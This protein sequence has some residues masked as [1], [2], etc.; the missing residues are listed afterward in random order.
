M[1][2][3]TDS[4]CCS[5]PP[6][7][8]F[9]TWVNFER[10]VFLFH[11]GNYRYRDRFRSLYRYINRR[12]P[13]PAME[14]HWIANIKHLAVYIIDQG[15]NLSSLDYNTFSQFKSLKTVYL[16]VQVTPSFRNLKLERNDRLADKGFMDLELAMARKAQQNPNYHTSGDWRDVILD[17][18]EA[19]RVR[20]R[21]RVVLDNNEQ[22]R[23]RIEI[24][25]P[26]HEP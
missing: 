22:N 19:R 16:T 6:I 8:T 12:I 1:T 25:V 7:R 4:Q 26:H 21:L 24:A 2:T 18:K 13:M 11:T 20:T 15:T 23:V 9:H 17:A 10:D 3:I 5:A 14:N